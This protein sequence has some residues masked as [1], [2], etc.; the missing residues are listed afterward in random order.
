LNI[1]SN[2]LPII[3]EISLGPLSQFQI[4]IP[5]L[6]SIRKEGIDVLLDGLSGG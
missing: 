2:P 5:L 1:G 4:L 6:L 3:L